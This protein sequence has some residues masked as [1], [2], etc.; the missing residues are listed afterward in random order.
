MG[1]AE[2]VEEGLVVKKENVWRIPRVVKVFVTKLNY[3]KKYHRS[4]TD[5]PCHKR[6][7]Q[8]KCNGL[9]ITSEKH[10]NPTQQ[11][12]LYLVSIGQ[13]RRITIVAI[14]GR[15]RISIVAIGRRRRISVVAIGGKR[16]ISIMTIRRRSIVAIGGR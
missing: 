13:K 12:Q 8:T 15:R 14:G 4:V 2:D 7:C 9:G 6:V 3:H 10:R 11:S 5:I 16:R 1:R